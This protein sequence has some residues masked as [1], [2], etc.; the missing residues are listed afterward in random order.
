MQV[1]VGW[2]PEYVLVMVSVHEAE[3]GAVLIPEPRTPVAA[4]PY[5]PVLYMDMLRHVGTVVGRGA[6]S[7]VNVG[8]PAACLRNA[9]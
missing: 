5:G 3:L 8:H 9:T 1:A 4:E 7:E 2:K 6:G